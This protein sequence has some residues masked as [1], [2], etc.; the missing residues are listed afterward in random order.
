MAKTCNVYSN[1]NIS[2]NAEERRQERLDRLV[3]IIGGAWLALAVT[4]YCVF[5][6][7][8]GLTRAFELALAI[9]ST[10]LV[11][12]GI[13]L[14]IRALWLDFSDMY[15]EGIFAQ[16]K[17]SALWRR[18][19]RYAGNHLSDK[20]G[21][22]VAYLA[23]RTCQYGFLA[24]ITSIMLMLGFFGGITLWVCLTS[25]AVVG[26]LSLI[27]FVMDFAMAEIEEE[28]RFAPLP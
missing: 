18:A 2:A 3:L 24:A 19:C 9:A 15:W 14:G 20:L 1:N 10:P 23:R 13:A 12:V 17:V 22:G 21:E 16:Y 4:L 11:I 26:V 8:L 7:A 5:D 25:T 28:K 27:H 6:L